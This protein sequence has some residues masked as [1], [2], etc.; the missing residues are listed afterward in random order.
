VT[1][2]F[3]KEQFH[4]RLN[5]LPGVEN[6]RSAREA[7][8]ASFNLL[9]YP[10]R[11]W[12]DWR[13]TDLKR[14]AES[15][16]DPLPAS[17]SQNATLQAR[18]LIDGLNL[19]SETRP[20]VFIDGHRATGFEPV[21]DQDGLRIAEF[22]DAREHFIESAAESA[23]EGKPLAALN[24]AFA[25]SGVFVQV[26]AATRIENPL[27][28]VFIASDQPAVAQ[29]PRVIIDLGS[30]SRLQVVQHFLGSSESASWTNAVTQ[31][32]QA[33]GSDLRLYRLQEYESAQLHTEL[34]SAELA[35]DAGL[36][37][38]YVDL[39]G[40]LVRNDA[41]INLAGPGAHCD[42]FGVFVANDGQHIDNHIRIDHSA[43]KTESQETFKSIIGDRGRGVFNGKVVVHK[44][45]QKIDA[46]QSSDNL[47]L[48]ERGEIDTKPE[49]EIY[50][51]DVK[52]SHGATVGQL[53][54]NQLFYLRTRGIDD[55]TARGLLT[56]AF[57]NEILQRIQLP[58]LKER[59][60]RAVIGRLP[61]QQHWD[62]LL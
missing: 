59:I 2:A 40:S 25:T 28:L 61:G 31:I 38:G 47:L 48:S 13:Y 17:P 14:I 60:A 42:L 3:L 16:F 37:L 52:C 24:T 44:N 1:E 8:M 7:A 32:S 58:G 49:L 26:A 50:A 27:H 11:K 55:T 18:R 15:E 33:S 62:E 29:Q 56:F 21:P 5:E 39:G 43:P 36:E 41:Q 34:L 20:I 4:T 54:E 10:T 19:N 35:A 6:T 12:E 46:K 23:Y 9:G 57:A 53:D 45:A 30:D 22:D 51:D